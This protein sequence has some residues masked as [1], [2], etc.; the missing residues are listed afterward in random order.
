MMGA[1]ELHVGES[2]AQRIIMFP[3]EWDKALDEG[4][5]RDASVETSRRLLRKAAKEFKVM[6]QP[7]DGVAQVE[8]GVKL[9]EEERYPLTNVLSLISY[10]RILLLQLPGLIL[11]STPLDLLF[12]LPMEKPLLGLS[13]PQDESREPT[14]L[15]FEPSRDTY[16]DVAATLP[17]GAYPDSEFLQ[18]V[19]TEHAPEDPEHQVHLL[20]TTGLLENEGSGINATDFFEMTAYVHLSDPG[21][22]GPEYD[23]PRHDYVKAM[24]GTTEAR[25]VWESVYMRFRD[26]RM[27]VCG[28]DLEPVEIYASTESELRKS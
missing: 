17:E 14:I 15:L 3:R 9:T 18:K 5:T 22:P 21:L 20:A 26:A 11:D 6:L 12:T 28:L 23:I 1:K 4:E 24:P 10:N 2:M 25:R 7:I 19:H 13:D 16:Q 27:D 8:G